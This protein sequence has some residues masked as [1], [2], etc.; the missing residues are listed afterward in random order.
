MPYK[1]KSKKRSAA[2][3]REARA[4]KRLETADEEDKSASAHTDSDSDVEVTS[5]TGGV[6]NHLIILMTVIPISTIQN[7]RWNIVMTKWMIWS[8]RN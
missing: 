5:W 3:A 4:R 6:K 2:N 8:E 1:S 7:G